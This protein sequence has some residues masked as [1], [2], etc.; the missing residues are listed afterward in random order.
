MAAAVA[1][2]RSLPQQAAGAP[3]QPVCSFRAILPYVSRTASRIASGLFAIS[4]FIFSHPRVR[5]G[6][7]AFSW[8]GRGQVPTAWQT[9]AH[10]ASTFSLI[11]SRISRVFV[12]F[13]SALPPNAEGSGK[14]QCKRVVPPGK[15][16]QRSAL[17]SSQTV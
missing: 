5:A 1:E 17:V 6:R 16:G 3:Q 14:P 2:G 15:T 12:S 13:T 7:R 8:Q 11:V 4:V 10:H 9:C